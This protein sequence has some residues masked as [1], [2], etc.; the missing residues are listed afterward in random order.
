MP[1]KSYTDDEFRIAVE[2]SHSVAG[3][4]RSLGL[5]VA[6]ANYAHAKKTIQRLGLDA[7]HFT[8]KA[9]N[10]DQQQKDWSQYRRAS[11]LK[12]HLLRVRGRCCEAC[13][14][15]AWMDQDI[16]LEVHHKNGDRTDNSLSN[17][18]LLCPNC[19]ALTANWRNRSVS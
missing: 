3:L 8:G 18:L 10:R 5:W 2:S 19:H 4:L 12:P 11:N 15:T 9:W 6:G 16:P 13:E 17:L 7:S 1:A 14:R